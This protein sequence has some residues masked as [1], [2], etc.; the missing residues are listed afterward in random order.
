LE[1]LQQLVRQE[2]R[3][4]AGELRR[5]QLGSR[6]ARLV[7]VTV[8]RA[9]EEQHLLGV[10]WVRQDAYR[11]VVMATLNALNR[12]LCRLAP[13]RWMEIRVAPDGPPNEPKEES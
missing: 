7:E 12:T 3:L 4:A 9:N 8:C 2:V 6:E 10:A 13:V 5:I 1:A 11:A